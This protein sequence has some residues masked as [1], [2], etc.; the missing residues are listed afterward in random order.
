M[1]QDDTL[2]GVDALTELAT[3]VLVLLESALSFNVER[4]ARYCTDHGVELA[5]H[6]KTTM[7]PEIAR[8][9]LDAGAWAVTV[10]NPAQA[11]ALT[12]VGARRVVV[13]NEVVD[14]A[15]IDLLS[16]IPGDVEVMVWV[17]S[18]AAVGASTPPSAGAS[19]CWWRSGSTAGGPAAGRWSRRRRW[20]PRPQPP[21][22]CASSACRRSRA[23]SGGARVRPKRWRWSTTCSAA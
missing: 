18:V 15:G 17:D 20:P 19:T 9:Q 1:H 10:A 14:H 22:G 8:R 13:A 21:S 3:P 5:P 4:M 12:D 11:A 16:D 7:S 6:V 23:S 2:L